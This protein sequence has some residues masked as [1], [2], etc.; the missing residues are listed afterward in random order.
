MLLKIRETYPDAEIYTELLL[1]DPKLGV[2]G[3][4][5]LVIHIGRHWIITDWKTG[6]Q[7]IKGHWGIGICSDLLDTSE[8]KYGLQTLL[9][10]HLLRASGYAEA[11]EDIETHVI[12]LADD[13]DEAVPREMD[14]SDEKNLQGHLN[15]MLFG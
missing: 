13:G 5:D 1:A 15:R 11:D 3:T 6:N 4:A 14:I 2:A 8:T 9:Y 12:F 7:R 10:A